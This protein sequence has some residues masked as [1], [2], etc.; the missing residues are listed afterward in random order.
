[1]IYEGVSA[2]NPRTKN[3]LKFYFLPSDEDMSDNSRS[4]DFG[5]ETTKMVILQHTRPLQPT[6]V[7][8]SRMSLKLRG[9]SK[10]IKRID[11]A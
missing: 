9:H 6:N 7:F 8:I 5:E 10:K 4:Y 11:N 1:M 2:R 3:G